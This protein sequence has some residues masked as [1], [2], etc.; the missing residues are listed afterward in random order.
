MEVRVLL[1]G[2]GNVG[3]GF[4]RLVDEKRDFLRDTAGMEV[5]ITGITTLTRGCIY[6]PQGL[7]LKNLLEGVDVDPG[8]PLWKL[9][10]YKS[11]NE[12]MP[13]DLIEMGDYDVLA[14]CTVTSLKG[15]GDAIGYISSALS[16]GKSVITTNKGPVAFCHQK[17][18]ELA[19]D[20][21]AR[22]LFEGTVMSGT[23]LFSTF[24]SGMGG[25]RVNSFEGV[26]NGTCNY[27]LERMH[28][29]LDF[30]SA[31]NEASL[32]GYAE[33]DPSMDIKGYD[34]ALKALIISN[35]MMEGRD[36]SFEDIELSGIED[37]PSDLL[38]AARCGEGR[39]RLVARGVCHRGSKN[40]SVGPELIQKGH[41]L[42]SLPGSMNG[43]VLDT[44]TM[45]RIAVTGAGAGSRETGSALLHDLVAVSRSH[46]KVEI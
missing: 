25:S 34:T 33:A 12:L 16:K 11:P 8:K 20:M 9:S 37:I 32:L 17:L 28:E 24:Q 36:V 23:P 46:L 27:I 44:D 35:V 26:L 7:D 29:G 21:G 10:G 43:I 4:C 40:L 31:L 14:E 45:G 1:M 41:P 15:G 18:N 3:K 2:F 13:V 42:Y 22:I 38:D 30:N 6:D 39:L 19:R 5:R